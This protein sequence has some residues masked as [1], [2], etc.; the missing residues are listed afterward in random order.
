MRDNIVKLR[1]SSISRVFSQWGTSSP[2]RIAAAV[3]LPSPAIPVLYPT[4][5]RRQCAIYRWRAAAAIW[6]V[7][8][9]PTPRASSTITPTTE[10]PPLAP[11]PTWR[12][13]VLT[14]RSSPRPAAPWERRAWWLCSFYLIHT[15]IF[16]ILYFTLLVFQYFYRF[17]KIVIKNILLWHHLK[18]DFE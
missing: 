17:L 6:T 9:P 8:L 1:L 14:W 11:S 10:I 2:V 12:G 13:P 16:N 5:A 4:S 18:N 7:S 3:L 15:Q